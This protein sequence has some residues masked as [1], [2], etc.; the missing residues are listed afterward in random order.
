MRFTSRHKINC[1]RRF[2][3][4]SLCLTRT[5]ERI[6][7]IH[8]STALPFTAVNETSID[9]L[10]LVSV[11]LHI[12]YNASSRIFNYFYASAIYLT[13][14]R[15]DFFFFSQEFDCRNNVLLLV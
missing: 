10:I 7:L 13:E 11:G 6:I 14:F 1:G 8:E 4:D 5:V 2:R 3:A 15:P 12:L 9:S